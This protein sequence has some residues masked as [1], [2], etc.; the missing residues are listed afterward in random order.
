MKGIERI[1]GAYVH[2]RRTR[3]LAEAAAR[4]LPRGVSVV[5]I[6]CGDG[7][8]A[9]LLS[10]L[11]PDLEITGV[12]VAPRPTCRVPVIAFDGEHLPFADGHFGASVLIDVLH[13]TRA[14]A[15]LLREA[16]RVSGGRVLLKDHTRT[17]RLSGLI[18]R[19]MDET[20]NRRHRVALPFNYLGPDEWSRAYADAN[21]EVEASDPVSRL[22][23]FP[24]S[25]VFG[26]RLQ[27][28]ALLRPRRP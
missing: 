1:H 23:P 14:P 2:S 28:M 8:F 3:V 22:Y 4:L 10:E 25:L 12:E 21:M 27:F 7:L 20:G 19:F 13:H 15:A 17:G 26:G 6:G 9:A 24:A 18:L 16:A 5:D 11:R